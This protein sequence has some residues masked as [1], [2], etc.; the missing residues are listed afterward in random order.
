MKQIMLT[1]IKDLQEMGNTVIEEPKPNYWQ[2]WEAGNGSY[3]Q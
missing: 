3:Y 2:S 1:D